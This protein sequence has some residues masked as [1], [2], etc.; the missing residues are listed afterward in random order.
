[1]WSLSSVSIDVLLQSK[2]MPKC[3]LTVITLP[4]TMA[5]VWADSLDVSRQIAE[6]SKDFITLATFIA[7]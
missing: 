6:R 5:H 7:F 3:F 1:M 2:R 4:F